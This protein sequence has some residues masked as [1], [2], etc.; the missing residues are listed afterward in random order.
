MIMAKELSRLARNGRLSYEIRDMVI[1]NNIH[2]ITLD[3]AINTIEGNVDNF[4]LFA[5]LYE[6]ESQRTS[7]RLKAAFKVNAQEGK[8]KGSI[9]PLG[10]RVED[11]Q[12]YVRNDSNPDIVKR[13]FRNF[14]QG[15]GY[16]A[17][18]RELNDEGI[19]TPSQIA[20]KVKSSDSWLGSGVRVILTNQN[21][22]GDMVQGK[23]TTKNV[24]ID[25]RKY[26]ETNEFIIVPNHHEAIISRNEFETVQQLIKS[27][28]R[29]RPQ[30]EVHLFTNT[31][32]CADC[33]RGMQ[34]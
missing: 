24:T 3:N 16:D 25:S 29:K 18:A 30:P 20:G 27:R 12:L 10:Y 33:G 19:P 26:M 34:Y 13:I 17:I 21:Y 22:V 6:Q 5:W 1:Q 28:H 14:L 2:I 9:P 23:S 4:G 11:G 31:A 32:F 8:F 15:K 7:N